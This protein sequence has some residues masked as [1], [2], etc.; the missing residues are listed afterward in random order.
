MTSVDTMRTPRP[1][2]SPGTRAFP[3][4][5]RTRLAL[6][7]PVRAL[8]VR[9]RAAFIVAFCWLI[10]IAGAGPAMAQINVNIVSPAADVP[11]DEQMPVVV[12]VTSPSEVTSVQ[13]AVGTQ[14]VALTS[15]PTNWTG[16]ISLAGLP[17]GSHQLVV[18]ATNAA[19]QTQ[20]ATRTFLFDKQPVLTVT[21]PANDTLGQPDVRVA[22][23]CTDDGPSCVIAVSVAGGGQM[24]VGNGSIDALIR[25]PDGV[26]TLEITARD[27]MNRT[28]QALRR[29]LVTTNPKLTPTATYPG[30][31]LDLQADRALVYDT[32]TSPFTLRIVNRATNANQTIWTA[33]ANE[34][35]VTGAYLTPGGAIFIIRSAVN[36]LTQLREWRDGALVNLGGVHPTSLE[37]KGQ[38]AIYNAAQSGLAPLILRDLITGT[39][40]IVDAHAGNNNNDVTADGRVVFWDYPVS[41][42]YQIIEYAPGPPSSITPLTAHPSKASVFP[43]TDGVNIVFTRFDPNFQPMEVSIVLRAGDG[44]ETVLATHFGTLPLLPADHFHVAGGWVAFTRP[45]TGGSTQVWVRAPDG[46]ERQLSSTG[47][48]AFVRGVNETGEVIF[49]TYQSGTTYRRHLARPDGTILDLGEAIGKVHL[50]DGAWY[51]SDAGQVLAITPDAATRS[52]LSEGATGTFFTTDVAILN[53]NNTDVPV[54]IRYLRE[55]APELEETRTLPAMSRTTIHEDDIPG[56]EGTSVSTVVEAPATS[57]VV[58]ERLMS[59]DANGYGGHLGTS[60]DRARPRWM[61]AEGAQGFFY[62][63]FLIANSG[64][65]EATV[66]FTFLLEQ[67]TPVTHAV[68]V[69][70]GARKTVYA[71]DVADL[72][73]RSF[74]TV[75]ESDVPIVAERA[76]YFG[77]A[78]LWLGG[79]GS[80]GVPEPAHKWFH[81]EGAT[82]SLFDTFILLANPN[83]VDVTV[84][85]TYTTEAGQV[86]VRPHPLPASSRLTINLENEAPEL[87][88][89]A[90][91]TRVES[92]SYP[93]VSERAMYWGTTGTGWREAHNSFGVTDSDLKWGL[94]EGR[95]GGPRGYQTYVLVSNSSPNPLAL[96][97]TFIKENGT[98]VER[99]YNVPR[100][101]RHNI[102]STDIEELADSNF[103][104][105]VE[106]TNG[107]PFNVESAIYWNT[108]SVIWEGGGNTV[109]TRLP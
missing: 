102:A 101:T 26:S 79:H 93:I 55:N 65:N 3:F 52:I 105:I 109:G 23:S 7:L 24:A 40:T 77:D 46:T 8:P 108:N 31:I 41:G 100:E 64:A 62:T 88:V 4:R 86:I 39:N 57:P 43:V 30:N 97:V 50:I 94:A 75:I 51:E 67:G 33:N 104:T 58:V 35:A 29:V 11:Q 61:F 28:T 71:G 56:L 22:A 84:N 73:N 92:T 80:A 103:S 99:T 32:L 98:K 78:P 63:F 106:S 47:S 6:A 21:S 15:S 36:F 66:T 96:R 10:A 82:G 25:P 90:V 37:V 42:P 59:W 81:A 1:S 18:T 49:D 85:V 74:A 14:T 69:A 54:T 95:S 45:G 83:P 2:L 70:P 60:V 34:E 19:A 76:M 53:P 20:Q 87:A 91:S 9:A 17:R 107:T 13:A 48:H 16:T 5:G 12:K 27:S 38:W 89:A 68:T 72:I 44:T